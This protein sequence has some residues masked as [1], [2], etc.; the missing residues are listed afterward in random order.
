MPEICLLCADEV[1]YWAIGHCDHPICSLCALR[2]KFL[3]REICCSVCKQNVDIMVVFRASDYE[4]NRNFH[5]FGIFDFTPAPGLRSDESMG[6]VFVNCD[7]HFLELDTMRSI[8]CPMPGCHLRFGSITALQSHTPK[9]HHK[10]LC[11]LCIKHRPLFISEHNLYTDD[12]LDR[13]IRSPPGALVGSGGDKGGGH[14]ACK[15]CGHRCF[16]A[17]QLI[18]HFREVHP[19]CPLCSPSLPILGFYRDQ[20]VLIE[21]IKQT[22]YVCSICS[23]SSSDSTT[24]YSTSFLTP[25]EL[26]AH[27]RSTHGVQNARVPVGVSFH[28]K[29][30]SNK[31]W[32]NPGTQEFIRLDTSS[33]DPYDTAATRKRQHDEKK[34]SHGS[35]PG[36]QPRRTAP[37]QHVIPFNMRVAGRVTGS[38]R[39]NRDPGDA[40]HFPTED[41]AQTSSSN[42]RSALNRNRRQEEFPALSEVQ[43]PPPPPTPSSSRPSWVTVTADTSSSAPS[44]SH[45]ISA[46]QSRCLGLGGAVVGAG[47]ALL[48]EQRM[49][50][51]REREAKEKERRREERNKVRGPNRPLCLEHNV[52]AGSRCYCLTISSE[53][54]QFRT[55]TQY[56]PLCNITRCTSQLTDQTP[57]PQQALAEALEIDGLRSICPTASFSGDPQLMQRPIYSASL[58]TWAASQRLLLQRLEKK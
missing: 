8:T 5:S 44:P 21:H 6:M 53:Y 41:R 30:T 50:Q 1:K 23:E 16:D 45:A 13:H 49:A 31:T 51:E 39:F 17:Q 52:S 28:F 55:Y 11:R 54:Q 14:P 56:T 58:L 3:S 24:L 2:L 35:S 15:F 47:A 46:M 40:G 43:Y 36:A 25:A 20:A 12:E 27:M 32:R 57:P 4:S 22:H 10:K 48:S 26:E 42:P 37:S 34:I 18:H 29:P 9:A 38:G 7:E 33:P 19:T